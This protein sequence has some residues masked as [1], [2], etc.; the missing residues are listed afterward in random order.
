MQVALVVIR[1]CSVVGGGHSAHKW[2]P[3]VSAEMGLDQAGQGPS[4][5]RIH[6]PP[7]WKARDDDKRV[8]ITDRRYLRSPAAAFLGLGT[9]RFITAHGRPRTTWTPKPATATTPTL[10]GESKRRKTPLC[11]A[12]SLRKVGKMNPWNAFFL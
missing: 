9:A 6:S 5:V 3:P 1:C 12:L 11:S 7:F 4:S 2:A 8:L 10:T